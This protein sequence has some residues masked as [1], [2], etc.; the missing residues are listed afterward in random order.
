[1]IK[2]LENIYVD[3]HHLEARV[4]QLYKDSDESTSVHLT[5]LQLDLSSALSVL[6]DLLGKE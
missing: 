5:S 4:H 2:T 3:L 6:E 1:M